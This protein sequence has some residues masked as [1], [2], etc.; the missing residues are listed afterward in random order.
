MWWHRSTNARSCPPC[1]TFAALALAMARDGSS[2]GVIRIACIDATGVERQVR[3]P[4]SLSSVA[5]AWRLWSSMGTDTSCVTLISLRFSRAKR[6]QLSGRS[7][8]NSRRLI[9][10]RDDTPRPDTMICCSQRLALTGASKS[11]TFP[12]VIC[13]TP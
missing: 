6:C 8:W 4:P 13:F 7:R 1:P 2:G 3:Q 9:H 10:A 12:L 5:G 11:V